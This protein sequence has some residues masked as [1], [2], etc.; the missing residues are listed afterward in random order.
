M[1]KLSTYNNEIIAELGSNQIMRQDVRG[2]PRGDTLLTYSEE[3]YS[4]TIILE[5]VGMYEQTGNA[6]FRVKLVVTRL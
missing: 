5:D 3:G 4:I 6:Y 2:M 1:L